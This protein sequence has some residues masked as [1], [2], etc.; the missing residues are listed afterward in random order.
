[1]AFTTTW[2]RLRDGCESVAPEDVLVTPSTERAFTVDAVGDDRVVVEFVESGD[3]RTL[4]RNQFEVL[5]EQLETTPDGLSVVDLP[6][7]VEPYVSVLTLSPQYVVDE[8]ANQ[9][10]YSEAGEGTESPFL[11]PGWT[12]RTRPERVHD[13]SLLLA[14]MLERTD[15]DELDALSPDVLVDLYVLLSDVQ[16]GAN[17]VRKQV[18]DEVIGHIGPEGSLNGQFGTVHRTTRER[19][20]LRDEETVFEALDEAGIPHEWVV[21]VDPSKLDV[22]LAVTDLAERDVYDVTEQVYA[23]KTAVE[24][25]AKQTRLQGLKDRLAALESP[26]AEELREDIEDLEDRIDTM[27]TA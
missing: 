12:A 23:Q 3:E 5:H 4:W 8:S 18:G 27:L 21:G 14:D 19:R 13:D 7:G 11:R 24:E 2:R 9:L 25:G 1:M 10:R 6:E 22:V 16:H 26:E 15:V 17:R 20:R